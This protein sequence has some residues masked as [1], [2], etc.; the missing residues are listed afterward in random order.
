MT[1]NLLKHQSD[2]GVTFEIGVGVMPGIFQPE[3]EGMFFIFLFYNKAP[4]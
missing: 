1:A 3:I 4:I 2:Q